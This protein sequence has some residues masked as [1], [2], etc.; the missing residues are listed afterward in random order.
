M[1][2]KILKFIDS[3]GGKATII[4]TSSFLAFGLACFVIGY[5]LTDGWDKVI[6]WFTSQWAIMVYV[7]IGLWLI[8][9][10]YLVY[11]SKNFDDKGG[12]D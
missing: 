8:I 5:G 4:A 12:N 6:A 7:F 2:K 9:V 1:K 11:L 10:M 3:K